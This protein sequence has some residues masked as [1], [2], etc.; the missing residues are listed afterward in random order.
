MDK[1]NK[2]TGTLVL[3]KCYE[4]CLSLLFKTPKIARVRV[5]IFIQQG[6]KTIQ[7][8]NTYSKIITK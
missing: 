7:E 4:D 8:L 6:G 5:V 1:T 2:K 3:T